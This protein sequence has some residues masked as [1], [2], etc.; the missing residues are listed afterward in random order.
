MPAEPAS[1][2]SPPADPTPMPA[3]AAA[4]ATP[5]AD[6]S[7]AVDLHRKIRGVVAVA[8]VASRLT[9]LLMIAFAVAAAINSRAYSN[10]PLAAA[11]HLVL[12]VWT[13]VFVV[14]VL[15]RDPVPGWALAGDVAVTT[16]GMV[17]LAEAGRTAMFSDL[18]N[19]DLEPITVT[20]ALAVALLSA[21]ARATI[22]AC[23]VMA[24]GYVFASR[25][26]IDDVAGAISIVSVASWQA[27]AGWSGLVFIR[28]LRAVARAV[29][30]ATEEVTAARERLAA[31][32]AHTEERRRAFA[33]QIRRYRAL[34]DGPLRTLTALAGPGPA[35]HPDP[36]LRQQ[37]AA[38]VDVLRG[39]A[40]DD[41]GSTL[42]DLS[43]ALI[44]AGN[45]V[46]AYGLRVEYHFANLPDD[47]PPEVVRALRRAAAEALS[48]VVAHA[49]IERVRLTALAASPPPVVPQPVVP[50]VPVVRVA[51][52][53][54]GVGFDPA[55]TRPGY[56]IR[57][58]IVARMAEV[59]GEAVVDSHPGQG[60]RVDLW[61]PR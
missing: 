15:R 47:L 31:R 4:T 3:L 41:A 19:P 54:Q 28:R 60:T 16:A 48:N 32:R 25:S 50:E 46:A 12:A 34:H 58:S 37:C 21:S 7:P 26:V 9:T 55:S 42:T 1:V 44:E 49:G 30:V 61:W 56:G 6:T 52:V 20:V 43:L 18:A 40:P 39:A 36:I 2:T 17:A 45:D 13:P 11:V 38:S 8:V 33:E 27:G 57:H 53:D 35:A 51:V 10:P 29:D 23:A 24:V 5:D 59:G 14:L 22:A